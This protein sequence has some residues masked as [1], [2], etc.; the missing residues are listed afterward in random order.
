MIE[1]GVRGRV[2]KMS[3]NGSGFGK[4]ESE[5]QN[6]HVQYKKGVLII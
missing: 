2:I 5:L 1:F 6:V 4:G 3:V